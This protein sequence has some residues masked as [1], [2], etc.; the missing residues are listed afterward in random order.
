MEIVLP[1]LGITYGSVVIWLI[2]RI[3][4]RPKEWG[5]WTSL[6]VCFMVSPVIIAACLIPPLHGPGHRE[7]SRRT[8]CRFNLNQIGMALHNYHDKY[9]SF[10]PAYV[11]DENGR[12]MHSWRVLLLPF[13]EET[14]L[15]E[16]YRFDEPWNGPH[17][18]KL[19]DTI[20][21]IFNCPSDEHGGTGNASTMTNYVVV[22]GAETAWPEN[23]ATAFKDFTD[24][25]SKTLLVVEV[26][27]SGI[28]WME[29]RDLQVLQMAPTVNAKSG[30]G[31]S[32]PHTGGAQVLFAD[33][34][35][36]FITENLSADDLRA[37]LTRH[38]GDTAAEF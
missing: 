14:A 30:Q 15:Y 4:N 20:L 6:A 32:S 17:N 37:L 23:G 3:V 27:N 36:Q 29:P 12:P 2:V 21:P 13:I 1:A 38:A 7:A 16:K 22:V 24:G 5:K 25:L 9:G 31:I 8:Q 11:A 18:K 34:H 33:G 28:H 19:A 26:A 10:P 35:V